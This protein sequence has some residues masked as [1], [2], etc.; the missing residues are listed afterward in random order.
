MFSH[1]NTCAVGGGSKSATASKKKSKGYDPRDAK[2]RKQADT[3]VAR[4]TKTESPNVKDMARSERAKLSYDAKKSDI[5]VQRYG[6]AQEL[7]IIDKIGGTQASNNGAVDAVH[8]MQSSLDFGED[9]VGKSFHSQKVGLV[10]HGFEIKTLVNKGGPNKSGIKAQIK[11]MPDQLARKMA[12]LNAKPN[13]RSG[14]I[15]LDHRD[16]AKDQNGNF[17]G[18]KEAYSGHD[19]WYRRDYGAHRI[20]GMYKVQSIKELKMLLS[21]S[22]K[23]LCKMLKDEPKKWKGII[24]SKEC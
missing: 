6:E 18:N 4:V 12:W 2:G 17:I 21:K 11:M 24:G 3:R 13:R 10:E 8:R 7:G 15:V 14:V 9:G 16:R 5:H 20:G 23:E 22:N 19:T 1:G